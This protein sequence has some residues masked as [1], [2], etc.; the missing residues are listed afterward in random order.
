ML[1]W[2]L[3]LT[4]FTRHTL[5]AS[6]TINHLSEFTQTG[7]E[8]SAGHPIHIHPHLPNGFKGDLQTRPPQNECA[9]RIIEIGEQADLAA[10]DQGTPKFIP[11]HP[12]KHPQ[13]KEIDHHPLQS[14]TPIDQIK[15]GCGSPSCHQTSEECAI[16]L[17]EGPR[18]TMVYLPCFHY[19]HDP[20]VRQWVQRIPKCPTCQSPVF[21]ATGGVDPK[22]VSINS[23]IQVHQPTQNFHR[24]NA[25]QLSHSD[26]PA[27]C[28]GL[29]SCGWSLLLLCVC[30]GILGTM[31]GWLPLVLYES[32]LVVD[33][34]FC[35][36]LMG[37]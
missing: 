27:T 35:A 30:L 5:G 2:L 22:S 10:L 11:G 28:C 23:S 3:L 26:E 25:H 1:T 4:I 19:F 31:G 9:E 34:C 32:S 7:A 33:Q 12:F 13:N 24:T 16:C 36:S 21:P 15:P 18:E 20:C 17:E 37:D 14:S 8:S 6:P 29:T